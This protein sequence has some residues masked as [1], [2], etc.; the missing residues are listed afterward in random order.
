MEKNIMRN[1]EKITD[2]QSSVFLLTRDV[3][4][5]Q[6][7]VDG[8]H[9]DVAEVQGDVAAVQDDVIA[10]AEDLERNSA[11]ITSLG[12]RGTWCSYAL[13]LHARET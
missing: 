6:E 13:H 10:V 2:N 5:L 7:E 1:E 12:T 3:K 4:D 9:G 11:D 8:V